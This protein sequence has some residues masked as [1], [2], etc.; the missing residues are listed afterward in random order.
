MICSDHALGLMGQAASLSRI[1]GSIERCHHRGEFGIVILEIVIGAGVDTDIERFGMADN[2]QAV[3]LA[4]EDFFKP[5]CPFEGG[6]TRCDP[7]C[8]EL[9]FDD[10]TAAAGIAGGGSFSVVSKPEA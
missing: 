3:I 8:T 9:C 1:S 2:R 10:L 4:A 5:L 6:D 7:D